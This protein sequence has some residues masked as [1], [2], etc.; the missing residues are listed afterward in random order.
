MYKEAT[1]WDLA[2]Q[3]SQDCY[4]V[5]EYSRHTDIHLQAQRDGGPLGGPIVHIQNLRVVDGV[6]GQEAEMGLWWR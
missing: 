6:R 5:D 4:E 2:V 1:G 3:R